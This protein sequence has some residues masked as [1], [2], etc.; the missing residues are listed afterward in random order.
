[1]AGAAAM[2]AASRLADEAMAT[3]TSKVKEEQV[4]TVS[5]AAVSI[6]LSTTLT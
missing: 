6:D 5:P 2:R 1:M 4:R 3:S